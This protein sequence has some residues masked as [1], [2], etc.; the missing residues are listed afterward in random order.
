MCLSFMAFFPA[1]V[2]PPGLLGSI[3]IRFRFR[4]K[5]EK[6][7]RENFMLFFMTNFHFDTICNVIEELQELEIPSIIHWQAA[8]IKYHQL[9]SL[10]RNCV[11]TRADQ[12]LP[13]TSTLMLK[14]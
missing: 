6:R 12:E 10:T 5:R 9:L 1:W 3:V 2:N 13:S 4:F 8:V 7:V 11:S 14:L